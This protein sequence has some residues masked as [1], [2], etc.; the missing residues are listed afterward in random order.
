ML[1]ALTDSVKG[2]SKAIFLNPMPDKNYSI[3]TNATINSQGT[4]G[5]GYVG[6]IPRYIDELNHVYGDIA[7]DLATGSAVLKATIMLNGVLTTAATLTDDA[8]I[9]IYEFLADAI[10]E[11]YIISNGTFLR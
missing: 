10:N 7:V 3:E 1:T 11:D 5:T 6:L 4:G 9:E 2:I 8:V